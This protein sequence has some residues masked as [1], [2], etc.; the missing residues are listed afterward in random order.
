MHTVH[1]GT[2]MG[3]S[4][5]PHRDCSGSCFGEAVTDDCG[6]C[7][8][9]STGLQFNQFRDCSGTC[10]GP[11]VEDCGVCHNPISPTGP[12]SYRD[13]TG[14]CFG[15]ALVDVCGVCYGGNSIVQAANSTLDACGVCEGDNSSCVGCDNVTASGKMT[16]SCGHCDGNDCGCMQITS[17]TPRVGPVTGGTMIRITGAGFFINDSALFNSSLPNCGTPTLLSD[18]SPI[19]ADCFFRSL[20]NQ[21]QF[22]G[23]AYIVNH[24]TIICLA[25][26]TSSFSET[27]Q[28]FEILV[29]VNGGTVLA[30]NPPI[31]FQASD[32]SNVN[33]IS[34][35]P[36]DTTLGTSPTVTFTGVNFINS[37]DI[38]CLV[39]FTGCSPASSDDV[40]AVGKFLS[41]TEISC[42][43]PP[44]YVQCM[45]SIQL[46]LNGQSV[47]I[48]PQKPLPEKVFNF[49]YGGPPPVVLS[50]HFSSDLHQ[51]MVTFDTSV[52]LVNGRQ[53]SCAAVFAP[54]TLVAFGNEQAQCKWNSVDQREIAITLPSVATVTDGTEVVFLDDVIISQ[55]PEEIPIDERPSYRRIPIRGLSIPVNGSV[56]RVIP[57]AVIEGQPNIPSCPTTVRFHGDNSLYPGYREFVYMWSIHIQDSS[58]QGY[59]EL[60]EYLSNLPPDASTISFSSELLQAGVEYY[61]QLVVRNTQGHF[62]EPDWLLLTRSSQW[63]F[64]IDVQIQGLSNRTVATT[65]SIFL[66]SQIFI[67]DCLEIQNRFEYQWS[68]YKV[69]DAVRGTLSEVPL[70]GVKLNLP[71][72][73]VP[74]ILLE[75]LETYIF[76]LQVGVTGGEITGSDNVTVT[77]EPRGPIARIFGGDY[78]SVLNNGTIVLDATPSLVHPALGNPMF[79]WTCIEEVSKQPC[80]NV[81]GGVIRINL[82]N[83]T[84]TI[85]AETLNPGFYRFSVIITQEERQSSATTVVIVEEEAPGNKLLVGISPIDVAT[86][87][88]TMV[89]EGWVYTDVANVIAEW[90]LLAEPGVYVY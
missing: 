56:N 11:F 36:V 85:P 41:S 87:T 9:G 49:T 7:T 35:M 4:F 83:A 13:C 31:I 78:R 37:S 75:P 60:V 72:I 17:A 47:G 51:L 59:P 3:F 63:D 42:Q 2:H 84:I 21:Q 62:S 69:A 77:V 90:S 58:I 68:A 71:T 6:Y 43:L 79:M 24:F 39:N 19:P 28:E 14:V 50:V 29:R 53:L 20:E 23:A 81:S 88:S 25:S 22:Q 26:D 73:F 32:Y 54:E 18:R 64:L 44:S 76:V 8:G 86:A 27:V 55:A 80:Y 70:V 57:V 5:S 66:L 65:D 38:R 12:T 15:A 30:A 48:V 10:D 40:I 46:S 16:D 52:E 89:L 34:V 45:A 61:L 33:V 74:S 82:N 1:K 67:P